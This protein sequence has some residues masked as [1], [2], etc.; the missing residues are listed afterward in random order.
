[1]NP[2]LGDLGLVDSINDLIENIN[3][4]RKLHVILEAEEEVEFDL[5]ENQKLTLFRIVQE[6]LNNALKH[7][8]ANTVVIH[9]EQNQK[10]ILLSIKD[11]G[12][13]FDPV[14]VKKGAGLKNIQNRVFLANG[15]ISLDSRPGKGCCMQIT[16]PINNNN[17]NPI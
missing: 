3:I 9:L 10:D 13:G 15:T 1:M 6:S 5:A 14:S 2:S 7:A 4:T 17:N 16:L 12:I 8:K 11:D